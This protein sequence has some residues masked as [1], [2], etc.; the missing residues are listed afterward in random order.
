[1]KNKILVGNVGIGD[2]VA[3]SYFSSNRY[4]GKFPQQTKFNLA[5]LPEIE[6]CLHGK[7]AFRTGMGNRC[8]S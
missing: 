3:F 7:P 2:D 5:G 1:M 4:L 6:F 8:Y